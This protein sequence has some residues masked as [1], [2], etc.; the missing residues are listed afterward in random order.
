MNE[1]IA[2]LIEWIQSASPAIWNI[3]V[4]QVY[5]DTVTSLL[6]VL[7]CV[8]AI[9][10]SWSYYK[11][12]AAKDLEK[13]ISYKGNSVSDWS[14]DWD[15]HI[16]MVIFMGVVVTLATLTIIIMLPGI[17]GRLLNPEFYAIQFIIQSISGG[18]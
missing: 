6:V 15:D 4:K 10:L 3:L 5:V 18:S 17:V 2:K 8:V 12:V 14:F 11:K 1:S 16:G 9:V 7:M 13:W